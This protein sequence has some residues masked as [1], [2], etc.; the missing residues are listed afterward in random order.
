MKK[1][2]YMPVI[3]FGITGLLWVI[4][5]LIS[6]AKGNSNSYLITAI[7]FWIIAVA[8]FFSNRED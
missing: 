1:K 8:I 6:V 5:S 2:Q 3:L 4:A 7:I